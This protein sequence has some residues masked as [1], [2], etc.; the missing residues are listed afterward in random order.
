[1]ESKNSISVALFLTLA[2][3]DLEM[4]PKKEEKTLESIKSDKNSTFYSQ[5]PIRVEALYY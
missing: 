1:M 3:V 5:K 2:I 4:V